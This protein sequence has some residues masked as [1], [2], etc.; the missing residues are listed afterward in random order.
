VTADPVA[1][2]ARATDQAAAVLG[3]VSQEQA[4]LPTPCT[5]WTVG[6]LIDHIIDDLHQFAV[7]AAGGK[8][9][10]SAPPKVADWQ[11][12]FRRNQAELLDA[13]R[14]AGD[15]SGTIDLPG[16]G[17]VPKRFQVDQAT[18]EIA[19]HTWDLARATQ[20]SPHLDPE[21]ALESLDWARGAL[22]DEYRSDEAGA[23]FGRAVEVAADAS[24]YDRLAAFFGRQPADWPGSGLVP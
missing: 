7:S 17:T 15:L 2:L 10:F 5:G 3:E 16:L 19:T 21:I 24:P 1:L 4:D 12:T 18:A 6:R 11:D 9:D 8:A 20:Q 23:T 22:R 14:A 13:W